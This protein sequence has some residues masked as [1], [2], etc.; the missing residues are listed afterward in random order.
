MLQDGAAGQRGAGAKIRSAS[1]PGSKVEVA[2]TG[3][4]DR[5]LLRSPEQSVVLLRHAER[6]SCGPFGQADAEHLPRPARVEG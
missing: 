1:P 6:Q 4:K 3:L 5:Q 2:A